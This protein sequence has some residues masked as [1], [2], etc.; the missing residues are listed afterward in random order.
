[1]LTSNPRLYDRRN[2]KG[3]QWSLNSGDLDLAK[4]WESR[5]FGCNWKVEGFVGESEADEVGRKNCEIRID[6]RI[7]RE[8]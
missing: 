5:Y 4:Y 1:M 2:S 3:E 8:K 6:E 7:L